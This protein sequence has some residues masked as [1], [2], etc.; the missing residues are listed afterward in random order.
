MAFPKILFGGD[1]NPDQWPED[2]WA[3][4]VRLL[5]LAGIDV[6]TVPVFSWTKL[7][8]EEERYDL[9]WLDRVVKLLWDN[10]IHLC[11]ATSTAAVPAWM[12]R[13]HP[14]VLRTTFSGARRKLS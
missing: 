6:A 10:G 1:Y 7:Q 8:P 5:K 11:L 14:D 12:A 3:H 4:D 13:R 9:A 2:V